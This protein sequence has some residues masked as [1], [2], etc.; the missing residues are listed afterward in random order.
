LT[1]A[2]DKLVP[3]RKAE[4]AFLGREITD[5]D[6]AFDNGTIDRIIV[7][8]TARDSAVQLLGPVGKD[9]WEDVRVRIE[10][11]IASG[12]AAQF[13]YPTDFVAFK[14]LLDHQERMAA[15]ETRYQ[16]RSL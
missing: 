7:G 12:H 2:D 5:S 13:V 3:L 8:N 1:P 10:N 6:D 16:S 4:I 14:Y 11:N 15:L 9:L